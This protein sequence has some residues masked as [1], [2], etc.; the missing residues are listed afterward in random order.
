MSWSDNNA[1]AAESTT[2]HLG[3]TLQPYPLHA[4]TEHVPQLLTA[5]ASNVTR[6]LQLFSAWDLDGDG[7]IGPREFERACMSLRIRGKHVG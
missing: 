5:L 1:A 6:L 7:A 4:T 3:L 2:T